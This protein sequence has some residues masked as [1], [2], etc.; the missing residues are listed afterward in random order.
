MS[1]TVKD[2][3]ISGFTLIEIMIVIAIMSITAAVA[4]PHFHNF[5]CQKRL[6]GA[7]R[8]IM[9]DLM[10]ARMLTVSGRNKVKVIFNVNGKNYTIFEDKNKNGNI[11]TGES[12][13]KNIQNYF[14]DVTFKSTANPTF[15]PRGSASTGSTITL[16]NPSGSK[17]L[18]V[19]IS[20][21]VNKN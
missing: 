13:V 11:D 10:F 9:S 2:K 7:T 19:A 21:R 14:Y 4:A 15:S 12:T 18:T 6:H 17:T 16:M 5:L 1:I 3:I 8:Q 20:G